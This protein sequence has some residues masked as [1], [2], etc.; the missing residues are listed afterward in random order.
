M[1]KFSP[2]R[3]EDRGKQGQFLPAWFIL[4]VAVIA[5]LIVFKVL[6]LR[7]FVELSLG[8]ESY[9]ASLT[10]MNIWFT[11]LGLLLVYI[12]GSWAWK[13]FFGSGNR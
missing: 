3:S 10:D 12:L 13:C 1:S 9:L 5:V 6:Q 4:S 2:K 8:G 11:A 7:I